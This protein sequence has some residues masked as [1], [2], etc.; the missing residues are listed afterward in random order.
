MQTTVQ[1]R[2]RTDWKGK[3]GIVLAL[4]GNTCGPLSSE[5]F[6]AS[7]PFVVLVIMQLALLVKDFF[8]FL[9]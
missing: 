3:A 4:K 9:I 2:E 7:L 6:W 1:G 5:S 8:R